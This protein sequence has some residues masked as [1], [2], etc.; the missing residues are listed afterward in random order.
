[1][2]RVSGLARRGSALVLAPEGRHARACV[3]VLQE[4]DLAVDHVPD[5]V[6]AL[7]WL[8]R[9]RYDLVLCDAPPAGPATLGFRL[10]RAAPQ[11]RILMLATPDTALADDLAALGVEA[12]AQPLDVNA[13]M[14]RLRP[15][16]A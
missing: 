6:T 12:L 10:R 2:M 7:R 8:R 3:L 5:T 13:L 16:A 9:A 14:A 1:M 15:A 4:L 11:A